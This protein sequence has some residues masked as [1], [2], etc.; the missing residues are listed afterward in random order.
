MWLKSKQEKILSKD[1]KVIIKRIN[2]WT[3]VVCSTIKK[4]DEIKIVSSKIIQIIEWIEDY[5][6]KQ[7]I[8][9][10][11]DQI[12]DNIWNIKNINKK[13]LEN[14]E[15]TVNL[16]IDIL[17]KYEIDTLTSLKNRTSL[18][19]IW[20]DCLKKWKNLSVTII[21][22]DNLKTINDTLWH[23]YWDIILRL[24]SIYL[25]FYFNNDRSTV[26]RTWW[27]EFMILSDLDNI[28]DMIKLL[29]NSIKNWFILPCIKRWDEKILND[30][31]KGHDTKKL[32]IEDLLSKIS[33]SYW[34][35]N[36]ND[37]PD[38]ENEEVINDKVDKIDNTFWFSYLISTA[39]KRLYQN[40]KAKEKNNVI[41]IK[42]K[43][44]I[45]I[46]K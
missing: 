39:D 6:E 32:T 3:K 45:E 16:I 33:F 27:D 44:K 1:W 35:S 37:I 20:N 18:E 31:I 8:L 25:S 23:P 15:V 43:K 28:E 21:D 38:E 42:C 29:D 40:K 11:I 10:L 17:N 19:E 36:I 4:I 22:L 14:R 26:F 24:Y 41:N 9:T 46:I 7:K 5:S 13:L 12:S 34:I 2:S 30:M